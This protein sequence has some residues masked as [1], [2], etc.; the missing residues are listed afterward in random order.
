MKITD[1]FS[2]ELL[3]GEMC[4][5]EGQQ[6]MKGEEK[7]SLAKMDGWLD[8][9]PSLLFSCPSC[10]WAAISPLCP[11]MPLSGKMAV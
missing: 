4:S 11:R 2:E 3:E 1:P 6:E 10:S 7:G 5:H 9:G 8:G